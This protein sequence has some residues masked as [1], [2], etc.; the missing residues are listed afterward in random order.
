[1]IYCIIRE[2]FTIDSR[3]HP[4][5]SEFYKKEYFI[6]AFFD[7]EDA[8]NLIWDMMG[9]FRGYSVT[10]ESKGLIAKS[11]NG[12][13]IIV[14]IQEIEPTDFIEKIYTKFKL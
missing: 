11:I 3:V 5:G 14:S 9:D 8:D 10:K 6:G 2:E 4:L 13:D 7:F 12:E 1:M